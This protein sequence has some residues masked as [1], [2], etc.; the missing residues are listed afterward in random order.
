[1]LRN[2]IGFLI[3]ALFSFAIGATGLAEL[4][5]SNSQFILNSI[6][7]ILAVAFILSW[8]KQRQKDLD[9]VSMILILGTVASLRTFSNEGEGKKNHSREKEMVRFSTTASND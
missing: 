3:L 2:T 5:I 7:F 4:S 8:K 1:M 6:L 9:F